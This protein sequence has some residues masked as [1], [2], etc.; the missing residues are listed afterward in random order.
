M[1]P[2]PVEE[3]LETMKQLSLFALLRT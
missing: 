3:F 1:L 2:H